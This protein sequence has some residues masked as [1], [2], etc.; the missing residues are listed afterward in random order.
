M[1]SRGCKV[2]DQFPPLSAEAA[3]LTSNSSA[4]AHPGTRLFDS[5]AT[6][7]VLKAPVRETAVSNCYKTILASPRLR[8]YT[9]GVTRK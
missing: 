1:A 4:K 7:G 5:D 9:Y 2:Q 6:H 3:A 8:D